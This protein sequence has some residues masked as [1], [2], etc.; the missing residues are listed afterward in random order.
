MAAQTYPNSETIVV[1]DASTDNTLAILQQLATRYP[2]HLLA[3]PTNRGKKSV[4]CAGLLLAHG[5]I[6]AF[7]DS[8]TVWA[9]DAVDRVVPIFLADQNIGAVS[10]HCR[11]LNGDTNLL[12]KIQD[13]WYEGQFSVRRPLRAFSARLAAYLDR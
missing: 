7:A 3:L 1:D 9:P 5:S 4:L 13:S 2:F 8:D 12:T 10:G 6:I 11:A